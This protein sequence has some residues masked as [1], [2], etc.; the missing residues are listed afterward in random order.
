VDGQE[1][2]VG[3]HSPSLHW[4]PVGSRALTQ[5]IL[6]GTRRE[7]IRAQRTLSGGRFTT[8]PIPVQTAAPPVGLTVTLM[9][10]T[11]RAAASEASSAW[12]RDERQPADA[13]P[14]R[15]CR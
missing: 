6:R 15:I 2:I 14:F 9:R 12:F 10:R 8:A 1:F 13:D 7:L 3:R 11:V 4:L 5:P